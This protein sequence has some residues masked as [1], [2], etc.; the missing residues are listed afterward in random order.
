MKIPVC[1]ILFGSELLEASAL[2]CCAF[3][4]LS[5]WWF[6]AIL[7]FGIARDLIVRNDYLEEKLK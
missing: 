2:I 1:R 4:K 5:W 7:V 3:G 6:W